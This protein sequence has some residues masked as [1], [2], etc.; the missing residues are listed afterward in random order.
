MKEN[1][2]ILRDERIKLFKDVCKSHNIKVTHQ[3]LEIFLEVM[4]AHDH[5][6]AEDIYHRVRERLPT[7]SFDTVYRTLATLEHCG[8]IA[9]VQLLADKTRY[10]PN[11]E[12]HHH[13][14]CTECS[15]IL[16]FS[17]NRFDEADL[18]K[19]VRQWG[20]ISSRHIQVRGICTDCMRKKGLDRE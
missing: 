14:V 16:D 15:S 11:M 3:R 8:V 1:A 5:P 20:D 17:W 9:K 19:E 10:D 13:V 4:D 6:C 7:I 12:P 2:G 18:P